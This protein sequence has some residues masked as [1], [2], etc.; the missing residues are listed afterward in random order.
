[1]LELRGAYRLIPYWLPKPWGGGHLDALAGN[2]AQDH[3][4]E[5]VLFSNLWHFPVKVKVGQDEIP[6]P[7]FMKNAGIS[8]EQ[9]P[10]M[11]KIL[12]TAAPMSL[13]NHPSDADVARLKLE[14][15]GK[16][17]CWAILDIDQYAHAYLGLKENLDPAILH[18]LQSDVDVFP[19]FN[20]YALKR[21]DIIKIH[22][23]LI[24]GT[25]GRLL[26][27]EIQQPSDHTFRIY[28][29]GRGRSL[30]VD[31]AISCMQS[32][33][34]ELSTYNDTLVT[35]SFK[36]LF[37]SVTGESQISRTGTGF[38]VVTWFGGKAEFMSGKD[39]LELSWGDSLIVLTQDPF[40]V[41]NIQNPSE[42]KAGDLPELNMLFEACVISRDS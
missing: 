5:C 20:E 32:Q 30:H 28:D 7:D 21:G 13:Q 37:H 42:Q 4:G 15:K 18:S 3:I 36:V 34:A 33:K 22:P 1:M 35:D 26:F 23:G 25:T 24:H 14:G 19:Y 11:L 39:R 12:S 41:R 38:S 29:F 27:Y 8:S 2:S 10:F 6:L 40:T 16:F 17:E 31:E 9:L